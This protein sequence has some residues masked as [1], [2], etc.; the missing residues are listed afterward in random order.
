MADYISFDDFDKTDVKQ[1]MKELDRREH[2]ID[3]KLAALLP[4]YK[5]LQSQYIHL[6]YRKEALNKKYADINV[7]YF[8]PQTKEDGDIAHKL[9]HP[10]DSENREITAELNELKS[11]E[12][13]AIANR[14]KYLRGKKSQIAIERRMLEDRIKN[15]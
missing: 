13:D 14:V 11:G 1:W 6:L 8:Y 5:Q 12:Y 7:K 4:D 3:V 10:L 2:N 15:L 9:L